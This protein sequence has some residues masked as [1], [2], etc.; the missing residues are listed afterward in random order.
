MTRGLRSVFLFGFLA[1]AL[2][3]CGGGGGGG[4]DGGGAPPANPGTTPPP[5]V[6][7]V[8]LAQ[9]KGSWFGMFDS[10]GTM[11]PIQIDIDDKGNITLVK[12]PNSDNL[13]G[14]VTKASDGPRLFRFVLTDKNDPQNKPFNQG[15]LM[16]DVASG[17]ATPA[18]PK[19][20]MF[21]VDEFFETAALQLETSAPQP[22]TYA[23]ADVN[24]SWSGDSVKTAGVSPSAP[25]PPATTPGTGFGKFDPSSGT[26][27]CQAAAPAS[28]CTFT[29]GAATR[30]A[31]VTLSGASDGRWTESG[32]ST[33]NVYLSADKKFAGAFTCATAGNL[34]TCNFYSLTKP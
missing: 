29:A 17:S 28:S 34:A 33:A 7:D 5:T 2:A 27:T 3:G 4:D 20:Y 11:V 30:T 13:I 12:L 8:A 14:T 9:L 26:V 15:M 16:V 24:G 31:T 1:A 18:G 6:P 10:K 22:T 23:Q 21:Y 32:S 19:Q 25:E